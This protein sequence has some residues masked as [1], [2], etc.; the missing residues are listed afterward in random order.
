MDNQPTL[1]ITQT[2]PH[3]VSPLLRNL[4]EDTSA[5]VLAY[6]S[7]QVGLPRVPGLSKDA[8][9]RRL[10]NHLSGEQL[11]DLEDDLIAARFGSLSVEAL[12]D[13]AL[14]TQHTGRAG[15]PRLEDMRTDQARLVEGGTRRWVFTMH[16]YDVV[17]DVGQRQ[18]ACACDYFKYA[19][20]RQA[21]CKH[22]AR[23]LTLIPPVYARDA[24]I[25]LLV[26][27]EYGGPDT[28][29]WQFT[30]LQAA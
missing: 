11:T 25:D 23:G 27:R 2:E 1:T 10:L 16:G 3:P 8:L 13:L 21:L 30:S 9:I 18:L 22:L 15:S 5:P 29:P 20:Q 12:L 26:T 24:L 4:L 28:P 14:Q 7:G 17:I 19:A 6:L